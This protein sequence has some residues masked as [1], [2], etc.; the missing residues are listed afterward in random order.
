MYDQC[1]W[2]KITRVLGVLMKFLVI[3][4]S[5][6]EIATLYLDLASEC[7]HRSAKAVDAGTADAMRRMGD[8]YFAKAVASDQ[9]LSRQL[10]GGLIE[11][12]ED[13]KALKNWR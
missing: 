10:Q 4:M 3:A 13:P 7:F 8:I 9:S 12:R 5:E 2:N 1:F 11:Q 6:R